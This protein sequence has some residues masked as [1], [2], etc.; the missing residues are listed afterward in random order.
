[1]Y[2]SVL[3][4]P[5]AL[6]YVAPIHCDLL[7][8]QETLEFIQSCVQ[9]LSAGKGGVVSISGEAGIG[10]TSIIQ[11][12]PDL[13][14][15]DIKLAVG[16]CENL[17]TS[18]L[19]GPLFDMCD[20]LGDELIC[21]LNGATP[22][23]EVA[24]QL[25]L[26]L[27]RSQIPFI[28]VFEDTHWADEATLDLIK[29]LAR[30]AAFL[31]ILLVLT[32]RN[33]EPAG[34][35]NISSLLGS[36]SPRD[37]TRI[38]L[39]P[40][41][42]DAVAQLVGGHPGQ[43][44][45]IHAITNGNPF[46]VKEILAGD[47]LTKQDLPRSIR[48]AVWARM[49]NC[50]IEQ[51]VL[52]EAIS[53]LPGGGERDLIV[54]LVT[55]PQ[56]EQID[57]LLESGMLVRD[58]RLIR[59]R[60]ELARQATVQLISE[61]RKKH[62][63]IAVGQ[64]LKQ[65]PTAE[66]LAV[67]ARR[68]HHADAAGDGATIIEFAPDAAI[69]I[70][71]MGAHKRAA[72][73][74]AL[75]L[76]YSDLLTK[77]AAATLN[78][79][80]SYESGLA[81]RIDDEVIAARHKAIALWQELGRL[82]KVGLN[83]RWLSRLH[84]YRAESVKAEAHISK[85]IEVL[86]TIDPGPELAWSYSIRSQWAMLNDQFDDALF[87]GE[88]AI[89]L[90]KQF[91]Q[92][93]I[94]VH[95]LNNMGTSLL[96]SGKPERGQALMDESLELALHHG[97]HEQAARVYTNVAEYALSVRDM[98]LA[99]RYLKNGIAFDTL[100]DLDSWLH[101]L[102]GCQAHFLMLCGRFGEAEALA[103]LI[104]DLPNQTLVM[105]LPA[106]IVLVRIQLLM[107]REGARRLSEN[108][109]IDVL[110]TQEAQ[111]IVPVR[112]I[113]AEAAWLD[114]NNQEIL[115]QIGQAMGFGMAQKSWEI[116]GIFCWSCRAG[117]TYLPLPDDLPLPA[118]LECEGRISEAADAYANSG[119]PFE[120]AVALCSVSGA[121]RSGALLRAHAVFSSIGA[122]AAADRV[123]MIAETEGIKLNT[124]ERRG[125]YSAARAH[126]A[127]L[128][129]KEQQVLDLLRIGASNADIAAKLHRSVRTVEHHV[130][131]VIS[132]LGVRSRQEAA[133]SADR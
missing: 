108:L 10:K 60:H 8:R 51:R 74:L 113:L 81:E 90:A 128:T 18:R 106:R 71:Q 110:K 73:L 48:D 37:L 83:H 21:L 77:E 99:E 26:T 7:E 20:V 117:R 16:F 101:Y 133:V 19:F 122:S 82:D 56:A 47:S 27:K 39:S 96:L 29:V 70:S 4:A 104:V 107:G 87:W 44:G 50:P 100:H 6:A 55:E 32:H 68:L 118:R 127:G 84:W 115:N 130:S 15:E 25:L 61:V 75:A 52:L 123:R 24:S 41:S 2:Q 5:N 80:W 30:R 33:D 79:S 103:Q 119:M 23:G 53:I 131:A 46:F 28:L 111:R 132:K 34:E 92:T 126:P 62:L 43:A 40:L 93:E 54:S 35:K 88:R 94:Y 36:I 72:Q 3:T 112:L 67:I 121:D 63:H 14:P 89:T 59:F 42:Y 57:D 85:S 9:K 125:Q 97:Y 78:E 11:A 38:A 64:W 102:R 98:A 91:G 66:D 129:A 45:K 109:L 120:Q 116:A 69:R 12:L 17:T 31:P 124:Q 49:E 13:C 65:S 95:A 76:R 105:Q 114:G 58:G 22:P 86:E 1:M